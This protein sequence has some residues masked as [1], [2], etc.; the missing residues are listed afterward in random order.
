MQHPIRVYY[1]VTMINDYLDVSKSIF[2]KMSDSGLL[3]DCERVYVGALGDAEQLPQLQ[4]LMAK[5][6][7]MEL[8][9]WHPDK[10]RWEFHTQRHMKYDADNL[11]K[12]Y[13]LYCH[14]KGVT[15]SFSDTD[16]LKNNDKLYENFWKD[17]LINEIITR[18]RVCYDML[19]L[20]DIGYDI[21]SCRVI[22]RRKSASLFSHGSGNYFF[23]SSS[24]LKTLFPIDEDDTRP[25]AM[26]RL[27]EIQKELI[28]LRK[29]HS[30]KLLGNIMPPEWWPYE[31][32]PLTYI[33]CNAFTVGF[34]FHKTFEETL[35]DGYPLHEYRTNP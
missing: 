8:R 19:S 28:E 30:L 16:E 29:T 17:Y 9:E 15:R 13:A 5:Y 25:D 24:Y 27:M 7:K 6:P 18:W 2:D 22:P 14:S 26:G 3:A 4:E 1:H 20:S 32:Q 11:P 33:A 23:A 35:K 31:N 34:P 12:F 21:C 10:N